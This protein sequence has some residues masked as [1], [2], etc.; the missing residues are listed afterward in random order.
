MRSDRNDEESGKLRIQ[1][2]RDRT[3][4]AAV[5]APATW[6]EIAD[7]AFPRLDQGYRYWIVV[8]ALGGLRNRGLIQK[9]AVSRKY[10]I[11]AAGAALLAA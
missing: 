10:S 2:Q 3:I 9:C 11:T 5:S 7:I 1:Q 6:D 4:L 8:M